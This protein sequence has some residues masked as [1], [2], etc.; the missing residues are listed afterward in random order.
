VG[1]SPACCNGASEP[2][3]LRQKSLAHSLVGQLSS[4]APFA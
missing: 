4:S 1:C 3:A 2:A